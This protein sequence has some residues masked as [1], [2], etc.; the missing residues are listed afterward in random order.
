MYRRL[1]LAVLIL[2]MV[3]VAPASA[4]SRRAVYAMTDA[5][6]GNEIAVYK[7]FK[8]GSIDFRHYVPTGGA[9]IGDLTRPEDALGSQNP[10]ILSQNRKWY[11]C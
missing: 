6:A 4:D 5:V 1:V 8:N 2:A 10:L 9:G 3:V 7:R 11:F